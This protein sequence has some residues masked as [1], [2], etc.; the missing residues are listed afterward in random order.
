MQSALCIN[1]NEFLPKGATRPFLSITENGHLYVV[2]AHGNP[3]GTK[4]LFNE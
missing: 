4:V 3:L 1:F 2:K